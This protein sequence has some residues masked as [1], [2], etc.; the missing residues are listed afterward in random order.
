MLRGRLASDATAAR[1]A[2]RALWVLM[3]SPTYQ[4]GSGSAAA[5]AGVLEATQTHRA[6]PEV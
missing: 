3:R 1:A 5:V 6:A 4:N 2:L